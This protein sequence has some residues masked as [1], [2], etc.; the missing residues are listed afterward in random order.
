[1]TYTGPGITVHGGGG[2]GIVAV[3]GSS[4]NASTASG[5]ASVIAS[6]SGPIVADGSNAVGIL[7]DSGTIRN[8]TSSGGRPTT[9]ITG[10]VQVTASNVSTPG[11][12]GTAISATGGSGGVTVTIPSGGLIMGGW[13]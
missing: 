4:E 5:S 12:F 6:G 8:Q 10:P 7:A 3:I 2:L 9:T 11:Q 13:Q 1:M